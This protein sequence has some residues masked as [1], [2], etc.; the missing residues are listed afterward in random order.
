MRRR[1]YGFQIRRCHEPGAA[2]LGG[3]EDLLPDPAP[4]RPER[5]PRQLGDLGCAE[6]L[7]A[8]H[9][10]RFSERGCGGAASPMS[11]CRALHSWAA[12]RASRRAISISAAEAGLTVFLI[13]GRSGAMSARTWVLARG[14]RKRGNR[15]YFLR[16]RPG[17]RRSRMRS[18]NDLA[19]CSRPRGFSAAARKRTTG[20]VALR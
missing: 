5:H 19:E 4:D 12:W 9:D 7:S 14:Q 8:P 15:I 13:F 10:H 2:E 20:P 16:R 6:V 1:K 17:F 3:R 18:R 11:G